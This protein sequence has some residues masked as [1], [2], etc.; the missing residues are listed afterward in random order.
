MRTR[1]GARA[2]CNV[3][4]VVGDERTGEE[5]VVETHNLVVDAGLDLIRDRIRGASNAF[6]THVAFGS[7]ATAPDAG[8][9][10]LGA[11]VAR[12]AFEQAP[13]SGAGSL[14]YTYYLPS[15]TGNLGLLSEV[16]ILTA[17]V[18]GTMYARATFATIDKT[19]STYVKVVWELEWTDDGA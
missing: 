18:A 16:G 11:E 19:G 17:S 6:L 1:D 13:S 14:E 12:Y 8:Q 5:R 15:G 10:E 7:D 3:R 4:I 2:R 9:T